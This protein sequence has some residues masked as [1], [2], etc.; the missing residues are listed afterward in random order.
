MLLLPSLLLFASLPACEG[1]P[2]ADS[3]HQALDGAPITWLKAAT[4]QHLDRSLLL[5]VSFKHSP[6]VLHRTLPA[7]GSCETLAQ[8]IAVAIL[9]LD[10][11][12][13]EERA[14]LGLPSCTVELSA[15]DI[16]HFI[17]LAWRPADA[18]PFDSPGAARVVSLIQWARSGSTAVQERA[19]NAPPG[20]TPRIESPHPPAS[21]PR[22]ANACKPRSV[23]RPV[24][25]YN[26]DEEPTESP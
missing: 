21:F 16:P 3:I 15:Q 17:S 12:L 24:L 26:G 22:L 10:I 18:M 23:V 13:K 11:S 19:P 8:A 20:S 25:M 14:S 4:V 6:L 2:S 1:P 7:V 5:E 9:T